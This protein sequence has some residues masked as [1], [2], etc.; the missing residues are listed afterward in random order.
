MSETK[1]INWKFICYYIRSTF[2]EDFP[3]E[4]AVGIYCLTFVSV[5]LFL[6]YSLL[7]MSL[8]LVLVSIGALSMLSCPFLPL[9]GAI[10]PKKHVEEMRWLMNKRLEK[11]L[12]REHI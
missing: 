4:F 8:L 10:P 6:F 12:G 3:D 5:L 1:T 9:R 2:K 11:F 7:T